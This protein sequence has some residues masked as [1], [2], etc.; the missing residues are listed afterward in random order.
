MSFSPFLTAVQAVRAP[1]VTPRGLLFVLSAP[2]GAGKGSI[3]N[4]LREQDTNILLSVSATTRPPRPGEAN[5][6]HYHFIDRPQFKHM[7]E[8]QEFLEHAEVYGNCYGT[9]KAPVETALQQGQ[10]VLFDIDWQGAQ[11]VACNARDDVASI[12]ILPPSLKELERRLRL[13]GQ[14]SDTVIA[15]RMAEACEQI[16][17]YNEYDYVI[18]NQDLEQSVQ[19]VALI[20]AAERMKRKRQVGLEKFI[21]KF[22]Q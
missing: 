19:A 4:A 1:E 5:G 9:P 3:A 21:N 2:S 12:F 22:N 8:N 17:H 7:V 18:V 6:V 13:R 10:D 16:S 14:D 11:Q 20:L 15:K